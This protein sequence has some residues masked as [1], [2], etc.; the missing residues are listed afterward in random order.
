MK[1]NGF[2]LVEVIIAI[3]VSAIFAALIIP[4][5]INYINTHE[6]L[7]TVQELKEIASAEQMFYEDNTTPL[8][9]TVTVSGTNYPETELYH[10]YTSNFSDLINSGVLENTD[11]DVN[12][13]GQ[14]Y[15]LSPEYSP[16]TQNLNNYCIRQAGIE[17]TTYIPVQY[18]GAVKTVPGAFEIAQ[19]GS[20]A[21]IGYYNIAL[22]T[23][24]E[25]H[26]NLKYNW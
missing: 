8:S 24:P 21:E 18:V 4:P 16:I 17:V 13:F 1:S 19:S 7:K 2:T 12:Y 15:V 6:A 22:E 20:M 10:I 5:A 11:S 14:A 26:A 9:C 25:E 3:A 23:N